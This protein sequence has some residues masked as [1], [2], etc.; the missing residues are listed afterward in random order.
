MN[1]GYAPQIWG[2]LFQRA[3][4]YGGSYRFYNYVALGYIF[5]FKKWAN[6]KFG[7]SRR[8]ALIYKEKFINY[9][10]NFPLTYIYN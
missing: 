10:Q 4:T 3:P 7:I 5:N 9:S 2:Y 8:T 6:A 1:L